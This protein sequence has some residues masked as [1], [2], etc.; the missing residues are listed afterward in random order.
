MP[1]PRPRRTPIQ[2]HD[3]YSI[4]SVAA[5]IAHR[6]AYLQ[7]TSSSRTSADKHAV[8][9]VYQET[10]QPSRETPRPQPGS[11]V[12]RNSV[13]KP[14]PTQ[15]KANSPLSSTS[16]PPRRAPRPDQIS[17]PPQ[18]PDGTYTEM[19]H[20]NAD[21]EQEAL[22]EQERSEATKKLDQSLNAY[23]AEIDTQESDQKEPLASA[24]AP[25][26]NQ[27]R[28]NEQ[29]EPVASTSAI[30]L[31]VKEEPIASTSAVTLDSFPS[32]NPPQLAT[33]VPIQN[34]ASQASS[35]S[36]ES[37]AEAG[38]ST[39]TSPPLES[40]SEETDPSTTPAPAWE[41][42]ELDDAPEYDVTTERRATPMRASK[43]PSSR[44]ARLMHYGTLG[45]GLAWGAAGSF[46][47]PSTGGDAAGKG[48]T[49]SGNPF[50]SDSN[51]RRLVDKLSRMRGAALKLG[52]FL[53]IQDSNLLPPEIENV[54]L[55]VQNSANYMPEW[56]MEKVMK[57]DLG[58]DWQDKFSHFNSTP[59]AAASIG[60]VHHGILSANHPTHP[61]MPV[62]IKIQFPG[63]RESIES[64]LSYL[65]WLLSVSA[66]L[67]KGL[68]LESTINQMRMELQ[69]ECDYTREA[70]MGRRF[71]RI[72][73]TGHGS[74]EVPTVVDELCNKR[75]LTTQLM[76]GRPLSSIEKYSQIRKDEIASSL[77]RLALEE[78]F[79]HKL[80]QTDPN[81]SNFL[82]STHSRKIQLIDFGATREYSTEF[83]D[84]WLQLLISAV[85]QDYDACHKWSIQI[86]YLLGNE[87]SEMV[88]AHIQSMTLLGSPF[89][90]QVPYNFTGQTLTEEIKSHIPLMLA[91]RKTPPPKETY[92]LNRKLSGTF[93]MC[94][95]LGAT[96][97]CRR[98]LRDVVQGYRFADGGICVAN[99]EGR[100]EIRKPPSNAHKGAEGGQQVRGHASAGGVR[101]IHTSSRI[102]REVQSLESRSKPAQRK[103]RERYGINLGDRWPRSLEAASAPVT[104]SA[105]ASFDTLAQSPAGTSMSTPQ[106]TE[107][108]PLRRESTPAE[109]SSRSET[110]LGAIE[111][112]TQLRQVEQSSE[113]KAHTI[114]GVAIPMKP[115]PPGSE[116][117]CMSGC[118][119]CVYD[120][121]KE[122]LEDYQE[123][124]TVVRNKLLNELGVKEEEWDADLLGKYPSSNSKDT[125]STTRS[126]D[127]EVDAVIAGLDPTMKAFLEMERKLKK[128]QQ[129]QKSHSS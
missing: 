10:Y 13:K 72:F 90:S 11:A 93:L 42:D 108:T 71:A 58:A 82:Y 56:Q 116:D 63:I 9:D 59:F 18:A 22:S 27:Q 5:R 64:D 118:A 114:R 60:Q 103:I 51:I 20:V 96:V 107:S 80:M 74:F 61:N 105:D 37:I 65:R 88:D 32:S 54:L 48:N 66:L 124:L 91:Q 8:D 109:E 86:G 57:E 87:S 79:T 47:G 25:G 125:G 110:P 4:A 97:D 19:K 36:V 46:L 117:C 3:I 7:A 106:G 83:M 2:L 99:E 67:P 14:W 81:F 98:V 38:P 41:R 6:A 70:E 28:E 23:F 29:K 34:A 16:P 122:D 89:R 30:A 53:S 50:M 102:L 69:D 127:E 94:S 44:I 31:S 112:D 21:Q 39:A 35:P 62:A 126:A 119:R 17:L 73:N 85:N 123:V 49:A 40:V 52:Q 113:K 1:P 24:S 104:P 101:S 33:D 95:K 76:K 128:K 115:S 84:M 55:Q 75:V 100:L 121:Y 120:L 45:A 129:Q 78:L 43:V 77:L 15:F 12:P 92:S 68:F 26:I 111:D